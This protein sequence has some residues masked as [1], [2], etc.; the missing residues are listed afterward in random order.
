MKRI[1]A[2]LLLPLSLTA[3]Q[4]S[5]PGSPKEIVQQNEIKQDY[6]EKKQECFK[7]REAEEERIKENN[8]GDLKEVFYS[9]LENTCVSFWEF[10]TDGLG[11]VYH[12]YIFTD[13]L[14]NEELHSFGYRE[15]TEFGKWYNEF[16]HEINIESYIE[17][18][19]Q[20]EMQK[21][22]I[23]YLQYLKSDNN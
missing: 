6:F 12:A 14:T 17:V 4:T 20:T 5:D 2:T 7:Y 10:T 22:V 15:S 8:D 18:E 11:N 9:P 23:K 21:I 16:D 13:L 19:D 3:C 1:I